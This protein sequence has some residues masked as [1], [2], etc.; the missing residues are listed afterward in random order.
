[1]VDADLALSEEISKD[2][3]QENRPDWFEVDY[4]FNILQKNSQTVII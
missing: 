2:N 3:D 4:P 1:M